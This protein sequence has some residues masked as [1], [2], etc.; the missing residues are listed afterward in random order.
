MRLCWW[1]TDRIAHNAI[2]LAQLHTELEHVLVG[3]QQQTERTSGSRNPGLN[4]NLTAV[5]AQHEIRAVLTSWCK[6]ISEDRG[7]KP[8][9]PAAPTQH[10][11]RH[12]ETGV[13]TCPSCVSGRC[14]LHT[15]RN[16]IGDL[17]AYIATHHEWLAAQHFAKDIAD[18]LEN[19]R[20]RAW[21]TAYPDG[22][23]RQPLT[24]VHCNQ[25]DCG[26]GVYA[27]IRPRDTLLPPSVH[28]DTNP[29]H[30]WASHEWHKLRDKVSA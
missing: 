25:P 27:I 29:D 20:H 11:Q 26:G 30:S 28:C 13:I 16:P 17:G 12:P 3:G 10:T 1:H 2:T 19:L 22:T 14:M 21:T 9:Q 4:L 5:E 15:S 23:R 6:L 7:I 18:E 24:G 8:P